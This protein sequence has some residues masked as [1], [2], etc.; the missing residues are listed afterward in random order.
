MQNELVASLKSQLELTSGLLA[1]AQSE[2][3]TQTKAV[4]EL[5]TLASEGLAQ[6]EQAHAKMEADLK[7]QLEAAIQAQQWTE[8]QNAALHAAGGN[9]DDALSTAEAA[10]AEAET[11]AKEASRRVGELEALLEASENAR[12]VAVA[13]AAE[14][15]RLAEAAGV[16]S[17]S[18][19]DGSKSDGNDDA[20][21]QALREQVHELEV[22]LEAVAIA[23]TTAETSA[24][25]AVADA[26]TRAA[27]NHKAWKLLKNRVKEALKT[28]PREV[29]S[30]MDGADDDDDEG[31]EG[32][33]SANTSSISPE[34]VR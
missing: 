3:A 15:T 18:A 1:Q 26:A 12:A 4:S 34:A 24:E 17:A 7:Q 21:V 14:K 30:D 9:V 8:Q 6:A 11:S 32:A 2:V 29:R 23:K 25:V 20:V 22:A 27:A 28:L 16:S 33:E 10:R 19:S 5:R 13:T 31:E